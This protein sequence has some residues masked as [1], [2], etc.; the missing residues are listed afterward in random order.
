MGEAP[1]WVG[2]ARQR[3][4]HGPSLESHLRTLLEL[5]PNEA[6]YLAGL[7]M[8]AAGDLP[9]ASAPQ[10]E[11]AARLQLSERSIRAYTRKL[12]RLGLIWTVD[13]QAT[14]ATYVNWEALGL[15]EVRHG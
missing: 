4:L 15:S 11:H 2:S 8:D 9:Y 7:C 14:H 12:E 1:A 5:T 6:A 3:L 13:R 10:T